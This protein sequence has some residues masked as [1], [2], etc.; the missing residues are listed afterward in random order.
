MDYPVK[1]IFITQEWGVNEQIYKRFGFKG[2]NGI[3]LRLHQGNNTPIFA[4][5][6]GIV[7]E[8][9]NDEDGY[10][11]YL[12]I[13]NDKEG[14]IL[15][16]LNHFEVNTNKHVKEGDLV[17]FGDNTG[18]STGIHLHWGYYRF[19]RDKKNGYGGTIDPSKFIKKEEENMNLK[20][21]ET[22]MNEKKIPEDKWEPTIR[23][24]FDIAK[25]NTELQKK[26]NKLQRDYAEA[27]GDAAKF[28][29]NYHT[30]MKESKSTQDELEKLRDQFAKKDGEISELN[31]QL[32]KKGDKILELDARILK[33]EQEKK[34]NEEPTPKP[35]TNQP[36]PEWKKATLNGIRAGILTA[37]PV[38]VVQLQAG[39]NWMD[40]KLW[41]IT[42][43][44]GM[45]AGFVKGI[46]EYVRKT[47]AFTLR[48]QNYDH[49]LYKTIFKFL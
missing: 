12:K 9:R 36:Y 22:F 1:K 23:S 47:K 44:S 42:T 39:I 7:K 18:W 5:H 48:G 14:S 3:D 10:G 13:E 2:H 11:L 33:L 21:F 27:Q 24:W 8:R 37:L 6:D 17:A 16:H 28:E 15:G 35:T 32:E 20:W 46:L 26:V 43:V 4:P 41:V 34:G 40:W 45:L 30:L 29:T 38:L 19:P 25:D 31:R 49:W